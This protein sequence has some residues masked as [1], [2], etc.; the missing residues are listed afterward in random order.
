MA[1]SLTYRDESA[2]DKVLKLFA[3][4]FQSQVR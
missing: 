2:G 3:D 1:D 4:P